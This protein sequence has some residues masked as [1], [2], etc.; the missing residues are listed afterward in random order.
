MAAEGACRH[1]C[2][3]DAL[4]PATAQGAA[5]SAGAAAGKGAVPSSAPTM[6]RQ[7]AMLQV[8]PPQHPPAPLIFAPTFTRKEAIHPVTHPR[9]MDSTQTYQSFGPDTYHCVHACPT[10]LHVLP[11]CACHTPM[12]PGDLSSDPSNHSSDC[13]HANLLSS[14]HQSSKQPH[15]PGVKHYTHATLMCHSSL[16]LIMILIMCQLS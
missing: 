14:I 16:L 7:H 6:Q 4:L 5:C 12:V 1:A 8:Q 10:Y 3:P 9:H 15:S 13:R 2:N 11:S